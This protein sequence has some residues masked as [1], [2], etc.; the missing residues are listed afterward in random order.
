MTTLHHLAIS[1]CDLYHTA[2][3]YIADVI[4]V[5]I[6]LSFRAGKDDFKTMSLACY[7]RNKYK[8]CYPCCETM[9]FFKNLRLIDNGYANNNIVC[10]AIF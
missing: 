9:S 4:K 1:A 5:I 3:T 6:F 7:L 10:K 2:I 8:K